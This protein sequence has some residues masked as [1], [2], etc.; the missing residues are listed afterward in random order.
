MK[1]ENLSGRQFGRLTV[2]QRDSDCKPVRW[3]CHCACGNV[4]S[5]RAGNLKHNQVQSCGC[6]RKETMGGIGGTNLLPNNEA[7]INGLF[8]RYKRSADLRG[9]EWQLTLE[10]FKSTLFQPCVYHGGEPTHVNSRINRP[11]QVICNGIDRIDS[12]LG[13]IPSNV[14]PACWE[15]N[16]MKG[17]MSTDEFKARITQIYEHLHAMKCMKV[18]A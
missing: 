11:G 17:A 5:V 10:Q 16:R 18:G 12:S 14:A 7:I 1:L 8:G 15:C 6:L 4:C 2:I 9:L 13:Y 3:L